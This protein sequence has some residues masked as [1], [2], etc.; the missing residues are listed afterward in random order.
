MP[1]NGFKFPSIISPLAYVSN[2]AK[3]GEGT[4]VMH[5]PIVN[6]GIVG[7]NCIINSK[8]LIEYDAVI[9]NNSVVSQGL[10]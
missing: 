6:A 7:K 5:E 1:K 3:I 4:I 8:S 2:Q 9:G 10:L